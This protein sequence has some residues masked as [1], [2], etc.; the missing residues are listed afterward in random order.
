MDWDVEVNLAKSEAMGVLITNI[1]PSEEYKQM[2]HIT[3]EES[4][5]NALVE[6]EDN[7]VKIL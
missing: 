1:L 2:L 5:W 7:P 3:S 4:I 6:L